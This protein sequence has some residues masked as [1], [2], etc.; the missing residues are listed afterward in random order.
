M[1]EITQRVIGKRF[2]VYFSPL[3]KRAPYK[4]KQFRSFPNMKKMW[5][6]IVSIGDFAEFVPELL[7]SD[8]SARIYVRREI[9][10]KA[11]FRR[12]HI[13]WQIASCTKDAFTRSRFRRRKSV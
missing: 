7:T 4:T 2:K 10:L 3:I 11:S 6:V 13:V 8:K 12:K 9:R 1:S 5:K